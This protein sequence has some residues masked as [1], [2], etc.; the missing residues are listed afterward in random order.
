MKRRCPI[1]QKVWEFPHDGEMLI[2]HYCE[3]AE[4][5]IFWNEGEAYFLPDEDSHKGPPERVEE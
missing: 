4:R 2:G 3:I 1:C 5:Y